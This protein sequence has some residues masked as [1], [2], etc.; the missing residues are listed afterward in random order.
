MSQPSSARYFDHI[1]EGELPFEP[2]TSRN[3]E[4]TGIRIGFR[5]APQTLP[6]KFLPVGQQD[7]FTSRYP[8]P[9][10]HPRSADDL[11]KITV[12]HPSSTSNVF[13]LVPRTDV[14]KESTELQ[15]VIWCTVDRN[16]ASARRCTDSPEERN[17]WPELSPRTFLHRW[18]VHDYDFMTS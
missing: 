7:N 9:S 14:M 15:I 10:I 1:R 3:M 6:S 13:S 18:K 2:R 16:L 17:Q 4:P 8:I 5:S 12:S 11:P